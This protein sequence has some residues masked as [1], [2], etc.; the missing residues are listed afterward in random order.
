MHVEVPVFSLTVLWMLCWGK[1]V[2]AHINPVAEKVENISRVFTL[3]KYQVAVY[4][5]YKLKTR[6]CL[7]KRQKL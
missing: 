1:T 6:P 4:L 2:S 3:V 5:N 7:P